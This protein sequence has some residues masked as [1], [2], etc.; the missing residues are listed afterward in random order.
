[1]AR[2]ERRRVWAFRLALVVAVGVGVF[3]DGA[4]VMSPG[5]GSAQSRLYVDG[6]AGLRVKLPGAKWPALRLDVARGLAA[7]RRWGVSAG[8][9]RTGPL[10]LRSVR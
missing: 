2:I 10:R 5:V 7:D 3:V 4:N 6:G 8:L 9:V 1:M